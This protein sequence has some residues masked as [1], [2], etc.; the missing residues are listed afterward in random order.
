MNT[1]TFRLFIP[2]LVI[3]FLVIYYSCQKSISGGPGVKPVEYVTATVTGRVVDDNNIPVEGAMVKSGSATTA[4]NLN[5]EFILNNVVLDKN[6]GLVKVEKDGYFQGSRTIVVSGDG[7]NYVFIQLIEK[8][9]AGSFNGTTG[10]MVT[11]PGGGSITFQGASVVNAATNTAYTGIVNVSAFFINP[12]SP[13]FS[14]MM[15]GALRGIDES[16]T[17]N[18]LQ[19]FGMMAVE[20]NG[21]GGEKL[22]LASSKTASVTFPIPTSLQAQ[23]P[24]TIPLWSFND[25][26]GL[27]KQEG[28]AT[29]QGSNYIAT[30]SHFS[31]WNCD[32]PFPLVDFTATFK[33]QNSNPIPGLLVKLKTQGDTTSLYGQGYTNDNGITQGKIPANKSL[34]MD[35]YN[36][37]GSKIYTQTFTTSGSSKD[38]GVI[39]VNNIQNQSLTVTGTAVSCNGLPV[40]NGIA[41]LKLDGTNYRVAI[42]NGNFVFAATR[43]DSTSVTA[44][45]TAFDIT[46]NEQ[47]TKDI[48]V[49]KGAA[50][51]GQVFAC[52]TQIDEYVYY[53]INGVDY[54]YIKPVDSI[55]SYFYNPS[56]LV[57][58]TVKTGS[59]RYMDIN[60][61]AS[62]ADVAP[63]NWI[64]LR[65]GN[66]LYVKNGTL[67]LTITEFGAL[68][69]GY[70]AGNFS[71]NL[72]DTFNLSTVVP[73]SLSFRVKR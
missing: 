52:G 26:S 31:Y 11:I 22:Q 32:A 33:D 57:S 59:P 18:G 42:T 63:V 38:L 15:P 30:V 70:V 3:F 29:R 13:G 45:I 10:G 64:S 60:F 24:A 16:D 71:G 46:N 4:T 39:T 50:D 73:V 25:S 12:E 27:W 58:A 2:A 56:T 65:E 54:N 68:G 5:G 61:T 53:T 1:K 28:T 21:A 40:T 20:L 34:V 19:S 69:S 49:T 47:G 66:S 17:E 67:N 44:T 14:A 41:N 7:G 35:V 62:G 43:C 37:C 55:V 51:A 36:S 8:V 6:A 9:I 72:K 48:T 23:T